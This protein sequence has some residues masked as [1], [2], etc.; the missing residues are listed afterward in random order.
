M[1]QGSGPRPAPDA[2]RFIKRLNS[3]I[4][5]RVRR[6]IY[7]N[8]GGRWLARY[9]VRFAMWT[10]VKARS[11]REVTLELKEFRYRLSLET[12]H[13]YLMFKEITSSRGGYEPGVENLLR[14]RLTSGG[15]FVDVGANNGYYTLLAAALV[16][17][18]G[19]VYSFEPN[20]RVFAR[21]ATNVRL[22]GFGNITLHK[23]GLWDHAESGKLF[24]SPVEDGSDS[25]VRRGPVADD[26]A[27]QPLDEVVVSTPVDVVKIDAEGAEPRVIVGMQRTILRNPGICIVFESHSGYDRE[28]L[29]SAIPSEFSLFAITAP[30]ADSGTGLR[31]LSRKELTAY[32][33]NVWATRE[34][35]E[36]P[37]RAGSPLIQPSTV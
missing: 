15:V 10:E 30:T 7:H 18:S 8:L 33:G 31:S 5:F 25:L 12:P 1:R 16:G 26:V 3:Q 17:P 37:A 19:H 27:L 9:A 14:N 2:L 6:V 24:H 22:N 36:P 11:D 29:A 21:L 23:M 4:P 28:A 32:D 35:P 20:P 34:R 13:D